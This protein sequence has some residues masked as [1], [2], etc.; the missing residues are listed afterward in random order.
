MVRV[1]GVSGTA[2]ARNMVRLMS[3]STGSSSPTSLPQ[4]TLD[5]RTYDRALACVHCGLC[6]PSCPTYTTTWH[7]ADSPRGRIQLIKGLADG[8][9][10][11]T[12]EVREHLD[13]CLDCRACETACPSEVVYH[14]LIEEARAKMPPAA[15]ARQVGGPRG[16]L[17]K[18]FFFHVLTKPGRL[19]LA[20][21]PARVLQ[22]AGVYGLVRKSGITRLLP[23]AFRKLEQMLPDL[24]PGQGVWAKTPAEVTP[25]RGAKKLRVAMFGT[26]VGSVMF[27]GVNRRAVELLSA[28][29]AEVVYPRGQGCCG[30]IHHHNADEHGAAELAKQNIDA[31]LASGAD[32][33]ITTVAGCGAQLREYGLLL[34]DDAAYAEKAKALV[35]KVRDVTEVV[36]ELGLPPRD[37]L[38]AVDAVVTY[39]DACHLAHAQKVTAAPRKLLAQIP[40]IRLVPLRESDMCCGA[41]G[42]YNLTQPEMAASLGDRKLANIAATGAP[43][44]VTGNAGCALHI[45]GTARGRGQTL[46]VMHPVDVLHAAVCGR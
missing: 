37:E 25:A 27:E 35:A 40:G 31:L 14:E 11:L 10:A 20:L 9:V 22:A 29:G 13:L 33:V 18:A 43:V 4:L 46:T 34:R 44:C 24:E 8:E 16:R 23:V 39:H 38:R 12:D 17:L 2:G 15:E 26:C 45:A 32:R 28:L 6:L 1:W 42:T 7:E 19:R 3:A 21:L 30:A 36:F 41:A 5:P